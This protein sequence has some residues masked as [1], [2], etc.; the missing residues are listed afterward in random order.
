[1]G[2]NNKTKREVGL[3]H[4]ELELWTKGKINVRVIKAPVVKEEI[5]EVCQVEG[6]D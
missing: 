2:R 3:T 6:T 5:P 4:S 1:M